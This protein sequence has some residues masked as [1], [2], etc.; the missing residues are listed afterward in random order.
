MSVVPWNRGKTQT[1]LSP[2]FIVAI[3]LH[4]DDERRIDDPRSKRVEEI[5]DKYAGR[6][7]GVFKRPNRFRTW[8][9]PFLDRRVGPFEHLLVGDGTAGT[10]ETHERLGDVHPFQKG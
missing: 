6:N 4:L 1:I 5:E 2:I 7:R 8:F 10:G 9:P 3:L